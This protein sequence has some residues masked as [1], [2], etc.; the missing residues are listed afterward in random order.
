MEWRN[1]KDGIAYV[2]FQ[3]DHYSTR[4]GSLSRHLLVEHYLLFIFEA[5]AGV[6]LYSATQSSSMKHGGKLIL[7]T[8]FSFLTMRLFSLQRMQ[9]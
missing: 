6:R 2:G 1:Y 4:Y 3:E 8:V 7:F 5:I 9:Q